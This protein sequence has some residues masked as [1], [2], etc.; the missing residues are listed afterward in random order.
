ML[1]DVPERRL[2]QRVPVTLR[3]R[4]AFLA[5]STV[6]ARVP[7][8]PAAGYDGRAGAVDPL[9]AEGMFL[10]SRPVSAAAAAGCRAG[11]GR[12]AAT[13]RAYE[14]RA[15]FRPTPHGVFAGVA[16]AAVGGDAADLCLGGGHRVR[17]GPGPAWLAAFCDQVLD[18]PGVLPRLRLQTSNLVVRRGQR[19]EHEKQAT[20]GV[21]GPQLVSVRATD[22]CVLILEECERGAPYPQVHAR[23][24]RAWPDAPETMIRGMVLELVRG[25]FLLTDLLPWCGRDDPLGHLIGRLS[26]SG[27]PLRSLERLRGHLRDADRSPPG[28]PG[29]LADLIAARRACDELAS[30]DRPLSADVAADARIT[31]PAALAA[32]AAEAVGVLWR[33]SDA[34]GALA[35]YHQRF[36]D[37]YGP[38]RFVPLLEVADPVAGLGDLEA[39]PARPPGTMPAGRAAILA[40][41][42]NEAVTRGRAEVNLDEATVNALDEHHADLP[43]PTTAEVYA[44]VFA[45]SARDLAAGRLSLAIYDGGTQQ[46]GSTAGR[47]A[48]LL[49]GVRAGLA[50]CGPALRAEIVVRPRTPELAGVARPTGFAACRI[51]VGVP[52]REGDLDLRDLLVVSAGGRLELWTAGGRQV[53][54]VLYSRIGS[55]YM[56]PVARLLQELGMHGSRPWH[57]WSWEPLQHAVFQPR[58]RYKSTVISPARWQLP[59]ALITAAE[60]RSRWEQAIASWQSVTVPAPPQVAVAEDADRH[61]PLDLR[62]DADRELLRRYVRRGLSSVTELPGGPDAIQAVVPGP[63]GRHVLELVIPLAS[64]P[65]APA[66]PLAAPPQARPR[67]EGLYLPGSEWLSAVIPSPGSCHDQILGQLPGLAAGLAGDA[68]RWFWL[69][70]H[71]TAHG[72][73]LRIRFHGDPAAL[74]RKVLPALSAWCADLIT[75]RLASGLVIEPY[76]P[77]T[78]RYGGPDAIVAAEDVFDADSRLVLAVLAASPGTGTRLV[79]AALSAAAIARTVAGADPAA[80]AGRNLDRPARRRLCALRPAARSA[81]GTGSAVIP[82]IGPAWARRDSALAGYRDALPPARRADCA[83]SLIHM[84]A[85]RLLGESDSERLARALAADLL[86]RETAR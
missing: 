1:I 50:A 74:S 10:A 86:A 32:E 58:V 57:G 36:A 29:R 3:G 15:R 47:F 17:T 76:D 65:A 82:A 26:G 56:P 27:A 16:A 4:F 23:L 25:G 37:R 75:Q 21:A 63:D 31:I 77:E 72:P 68:D 66:G 45:A 49:P 34:R 48:S 38:G 19:L 44:R 7:L 67:G 83:S 42:L 60:D 24:T 73:H 35:G 54:P 55:R 22:A 11:D 59:P 6:L 40:G 52:A 28:T 70:Y 9:L 13:V 61:L 20:P 8:L 64:R 62:R 51:P 5:G 85:N 2:H 71:D 30:T 41:L 43:P 33:V 81:A 53:M 69:R 84:H 78:E 79:I 14:L 39:G 18:L 46:A 80:L 12:L